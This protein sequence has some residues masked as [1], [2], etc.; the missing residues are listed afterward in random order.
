MRV[1]RGRDAILAE[2]GHHPFARLRATGDQLTAY[3]AEDALIWTSIRPHGRAVASL[4]SPVSC[5]AVIADLLVDGLL[6]GA[7]FAELPRIGAADAHPHLP[8]ARLSDWAVLWTH[9][10]RPGDG[11]TVERLNQAD[12]AAITA[13]LDDA[14]PYTDNRPG[15]AAIRSWWGIRAGGV[16]V[17]V[18][19][20]RSDQGVGYVV[21]VAV[22][23]R[24]Q[25]LGLGSVLVRTLAA[26]LVDEFGICALGV[27][28]SNHRG[29][30]VFTRAGFTG[31]V[32]LTYAAL[33]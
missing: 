13:V 30:A 11:F 32:E 5:A 3:A 9:G 14:L 18:A 28:A 31:R 2:A 33:A 15:K 21:G 29:D 4:G 25:G 10:A 22:A 26:R 19:G 7:T 1:I 16:L 6:P 20:D 12:D 27:L 17:A 24:W 8:G 23:S